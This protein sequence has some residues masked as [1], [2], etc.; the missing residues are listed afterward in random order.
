VDNVTNQ[1]AVA[2]TAG[3]HHHHHGGGGK[4]AQ[5]VDEAV[6]KALGMTPD[7][8]KAA[9]QQ[10]ASLNDLA[11]QKGVSSDTLQAAITQGLQ[12]ANPTI[13]ADR[14]KQIAE[15]IASRAAQ[16]PANANGVA[17]PA[18]PGRQGAADNDGDQDGS[19]GGRF[20]ALAT[21]P[22]TLAAASTLSLLA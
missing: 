4:Q 18:Q 6:S 3:H 10:G 21:T 11:Q 7:E 17:G 8:L 9:R 12:S 22:P 15:R 16:P 2:Q 20:D 14:A 13:S 19:R 1:P 5:A